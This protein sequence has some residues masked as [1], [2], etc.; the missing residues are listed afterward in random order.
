MTQRDFL[1]KTSVFL[2][3]IFLFTLRALYSNNYINTKRYSK[4]PF[5]SEKIYQ[6]ISE[7]VDKSF[8]T[9][10]EEEPYVSV[11]AFLILGNFVGFVTEF[12]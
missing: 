10:D 12:N 6:M 7:I 9:D 1:I 3:L 5:D 4:A 11:R 2:C 8:V